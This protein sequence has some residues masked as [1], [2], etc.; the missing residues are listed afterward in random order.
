LRAISTFLAWALAPVL[1]A[2][3]VAAGDAPSLGDVVPPEAFVALES[4]V[5]FG[6]SCAHCHEG[7]CS[8]RLTFDLGAGAVVGHVRRHAGAVSEASAQ[9]LIGLLESMKKACAY[10]PV[11][12]PVPPDGRWSSELLARLCVPSRR[13]Y[14]VPL[15]GLAPARYRL[16][17]QL[18]G[19]QH[20]HAEVVTR[21]FEILTD[22][23]L[24]IER[25]A[26]AVSFRALAP[27]EP[28]LRLRAQEPFRLD[29]LQLI[30]EAEPR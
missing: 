29:R 8:G 10:P 7:E 17:L 20:V 1:L 27:V 15:G 18:D 3:P 26:A 24:V 28:F 6:A 30:R 5:E 14:L 2:A 19:A 21:T 22:E 13:S 25:R 4:F 16:E 23:P 12:A 11:E 9:E